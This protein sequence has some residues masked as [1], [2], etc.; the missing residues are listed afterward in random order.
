MS[1]LVCGF[2]EA[3]KVG[4]VGTYLS[5]EWKVPISILVAASANAALYCIRIL[6]KMSS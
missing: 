6:N 5:R 2:Q 4:T 3:I 1:S